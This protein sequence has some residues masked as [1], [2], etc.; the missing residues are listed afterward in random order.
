[1]AAAAARVAT[2]VTRTGAAVTRIGA[3]AARTRMA[4][5]V[6][7]MGAAVTR[8]GAAVT[9][10]GTAVTR[11]ASG[12]LPRTMSYVT[13]D[14]VRHART[15]SYGISY[16]MSYVGNGY[17]ISYV[18]DIRYRR[19]IS[20]T[21]SYVRTMSH[22]NIRYRMSDVRCRT[23]VVRLLEVAVSAV[24]KE[25]DPLPIAQA[26]ERC[27][28][29]NQSFIFSLATSKTVS[30]TRSLWCSRTLI[31]GCDCNPQALPPDQP[32]VQTAS[33]SVRELPST[34]LGAAGQFFVPT[35]GAGG[36]DVARAMARG[37]AVTRIIG[38]PRR[39]RGAG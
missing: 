16:T 8:M 11:M 35:Q 6:T 28:S 34:N 25:P 38:W 26:N 29:D 22:V 2:V 27:L 14:V 31:H 15:T 32:T 33:G 3:A 4:A 30:E 39:C 7:R 9:R 18:H 20:Y 10:M 23:S 1:M 13:Y 24:L 36:G 12:F 5:V 19:S 37:V 17:T 21:T